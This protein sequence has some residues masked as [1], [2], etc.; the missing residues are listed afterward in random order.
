MNSNKKFGVTVNDIKQIESHSSLEELVTKLK[1]INSSNKVFDL[2]NYN[3]LPSNFDYYFKEK[4]KDLDRFDEG[5]IIFNR[6]ILNMVSGDNLPERLLNLFKATFGDDEFDNEKFATIL[7]KAYQKIQQ[8]SLNKTPDTFGKNDYLVHYLF[9]LYTDC[10]HYFL[11]NTD[12]LS[13]LP[14]K[15]TTDEKIIFFEQ[16]LKIQ[17]KDF[18]DASEAAFQEYINRVSV[19]L[20]AFYDFMNIKNEVIINGSLNSLRGTISI[21]GYIPYILHITNINKFD[22]L[23]E[24]FRCLPIAIPEKFQ[25]SLKLIILI[26]DVETRSLIYTKLEDIIKHSDN[27]KPEDFEALKK[28]KTSDERV[29]STFMNFLELMQLCTEVKDKRPDTLA[30]ALK[31]LRTFY[32]KLYNT[33]QDSDHFEENFADWFEEFMDFDDA[34]REQLITT[35]LHQIAKDCIQFLSALTNDLADDALI[36]LDINLLKG[37]R[38]FQ[39]FIF[40]IAVSTT[41]INSQHFLMTFFELY[42]ENNPASSFNALT[43]L[44]DSIQHKKSLLVKNCLLELTN[45]YQKRCFSKTGP[46]E[47]IRKIALFIIDTKMPRY[48]MHLRLKENDPVVIRNSLISYLIISVNLMVQLV[49]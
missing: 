41:H 8:R 13:L 44:R 25:I 34:R 7:E 3:R 18:N 32:S 19:S 35:Q 11:N 48:Y 45:N 20:K 6:I 26:S 30:D 40:Q 17:N 9:L 36:N 4:N 33:S 31:E 38:L 12:L 21:I 14:K 42:S 5:I 23:A 39:D 24:F 27:V 37:K 1:E 46:E 15:M 47:T 10:A 2:K 22:S 28:L 43:V 29:N 16:Q 49:V